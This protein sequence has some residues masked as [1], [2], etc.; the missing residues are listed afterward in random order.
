VAKDR[1]RS[2]SPAHLARDLAANGGV[3]RFSIV[4]IRN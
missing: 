3:A 1:S 2:T 4:P